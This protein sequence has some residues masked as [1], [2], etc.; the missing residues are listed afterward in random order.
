MLYNNEGMLL[1]PLIPVYG[2]LMAEEHIAVEGLTPQEIEVE[3]VKI[4]NELTK[5]YVLKENSEYINRK[6]TQVACLRGMLEAKQLI[7]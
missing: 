5:A 4:Y 7:L 6:A 1:H 3:L 2:V